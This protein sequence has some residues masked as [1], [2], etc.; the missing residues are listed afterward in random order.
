M[1]SILPKIKN[2]IFVLAIIFYA[3]PLAGMHPAAK[4]EDK[5]SELVGAQGLGGFN[6]TLQKLAV[7]LDGVK[8][9][10]LGEEDDDSDDSGPPPPDMDGLDLSNAKTEEEF[11]TNILGVKPN[12]HENQ[13]L[14]LYNIRPLSK[15]NC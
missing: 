8:K 10:L 1:K 9:A 13:F 2:L 3:S 15:L 7:T 11:K 12:Q 14:V 5:V 4:L 6:Q